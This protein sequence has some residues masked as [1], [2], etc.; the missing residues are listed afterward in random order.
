LRAVTTD[1]VPFWVDLIRAATAL[2]L[3]APAVS[4]VLSDST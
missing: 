1:R 4:S 3:P 2:L